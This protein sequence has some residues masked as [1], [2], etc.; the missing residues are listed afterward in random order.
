MLISCKRVWL[1]VRLQLRIKW[2]CFENVTLDTFFWEKSFSL[3]QPYSYLFRR[4]IDMGLHGALWFGTLTAVLLAL[5][6][7]RGCHKERHC[8][9][10]C[11]ES[12][13]SSES[14]KC[15]SEE[16]CEGFSTTSSVSSFSP[17]T[18][19]SVWFL[20]IICVNFI[21]TN[22]ITNKRHCLKNN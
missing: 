2:F 15:E 18:P 14:C 1:R 10:D 7:G 12:S 11:S 5:A 20:I 4:I 21:R 6:M 19:S 3:L 17:T 8:D 16:E 9:C 13:E 22:S